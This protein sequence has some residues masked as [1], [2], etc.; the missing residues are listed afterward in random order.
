MTA[1][2]FLLAERVLSS[3][4]QAQ[5]HKLLDI[6]ASLKESDEKGLDR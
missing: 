2:Y 3:F 5:A 4:R 1:T 6:A